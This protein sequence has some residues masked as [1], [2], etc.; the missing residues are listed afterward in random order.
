MVMAGLFTSPYQQATTWQQRAANVTDA[1][2]K[3]RW[4]LYFMEKRGCFKPPTGGAFAQWEVYMR[5]PKPQG[6]NEDIGPTFSKPNHLESA[7]LPW[8]YYQHGKILDRALLSQNSGTQQ[9]INVVADSMKNV[10]DAFINRWP[11]YFYQNGDIATEP[12]PLYGFY[13]ILSKY[14]ST[15]AAAN[16]GFQNKVRLMNGSYAERVMNLGDKSPDYVGNDGF[17]T[18]QVTDSTVGIAGNS[19]WPAGRGDPAYD[20][21]HPLVI[22]TQSPAWGPS[23]GFNA[24]YCSEMLT[25]G[26]G[27]SGRTASGDKGEID[28]LLMGT[29]PYLAL[30]SALQ[31]TQRMITPMVP[32]MESPQ[33][34]GGR[35]WNQPIYQFSGCML[36]RD[37]DMP[38]TTDVIGCNLNYVEYQPLNQPDP[39]SSR[40][41]LI[42][43]GRDK[44]TGGAG[45]VLYGYS[46]GQLIFRSPRS[47]VL[48]TP[49]V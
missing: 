4:L 41:P 46:E 2:K 26:I 7:K 25:W 18:I 40:I 27:Y 33:D 3:S 29:E 23:P 13:S 10:E 48:W 6:Y 39:G 28:M 12:S 16:Q 17:A 21:W 35:L 42:G 37:H 36:V 22:K 30:M 32:K 1:V 31:N 9:I 5:Q 44:I 8:A 49:L 47:L 14:Y 34:V 45:Q 19:W 20:Y 11:E 38:N 24:A 43:V 15:T